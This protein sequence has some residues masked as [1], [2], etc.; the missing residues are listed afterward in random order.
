MKTTKLLLLCWIITACSSDAVEDVSMVTDTAETDTTLATALLDTE[1][2]IDNVIACAASNE[3]PSVVSVFLYPREGATNIRYFETETADEDKND[4]DNYKELELP[5][6]D[7]FNGYLLKYEVMPSQEKWV[8]V[9]FDEDGT[10]HLSNPIR[11]KQITKATEYLPQNVT[12]DNGSNM[13]TFTWQD[14]TFDDSVI[15]F[16]VV[17]DVEDELLSGTYTFDRMFQYYKLD[18]VVLNITEETPPVLTSQTPYNFLLLAVSEDN[19]VNLFSDV[20]FSIE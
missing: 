6:L 15:Y 3:N 19:W 10:T 13:P 20:A 2:V 17:S 1:F 7:V 14:G 4:Y 12:V 16:H 8:I 11:L 18:N 5:L 9:S